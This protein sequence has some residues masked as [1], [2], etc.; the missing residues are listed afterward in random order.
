MNTHMLRKLL[1]AVTAVNAANQN[2]IITTNN[3]KLSEGTPVLPQH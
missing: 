3:G 2:G 1:N